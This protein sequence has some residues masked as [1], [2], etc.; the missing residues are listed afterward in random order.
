VT[1]LLSIQIKAEHVGDMLPTFLTLFHTFSLL[2]SS[3]VE[4]EHQTFYFIYMTILSVLIIKHVA[5]RQWGLVAQ[6]AVC[7]ALHRFLRAMNQTG[8]KWKHLPDMSDLINQNENIKFYL[9][10][11]SLIITT[12]LFKHKM[13]NLIGNCFISVIIIVQK[14]TQSVILA[15]LLYLLIFIKLVSNRK[16]SLFESSVFLCC[17]LHSETNVIVTVC[18]ILMLRI[19]DSQNPV[20]YYILGKCLHFYLGNSN[21]LASIQVGAGYTGLSEYRAVPVILLLAVHTYSG[22]I[23]TYS[24]A[25]QKGYRSVLTC[26]FYCNLCDML[27]FCILSVMMR[28]HIFVWSVFSPKLLYFGMELVVFIAFSFICFLLDK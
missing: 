5:S 11:S 14:S 20:I 26:H 15:Q 24:Y 18:S 21:S 10:V 27:L 8:D 7:V 13:F 3:F 17:V 16:D 23:I 25:L 4:E 6:Y 2:S 9:F 28:Y 22:I 1:G 12:L 19:L